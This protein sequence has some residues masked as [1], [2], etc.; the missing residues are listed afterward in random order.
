VF[1]RIR[2]S[3]VPSTTLNGETERKSGWLFKKG[4]KR[5]N[6]KKRFFV[7]T[8]TTLSY[9][10][11]QTQHKLKG[12]LSLIG[13]N[14]AYHRAD[15]TK[16]P[17]S[18]EIPAVVTSGAS[19]KGSAN[20]NRILVCYAETRGD[21]DSWIS[22]VNW[23]NQEVA[24]SLLG[25][26]ALAV[27]EE[28][29]NI[30]VE[31]A[32]YLGEAETTL[33]AFA[34][35]DNK[36]GVIMMRCE[37]QH[38]EDPVEA[39]VFLDQIQ[40]APQLLSFFRCLHSLV[41][42]LP[43]HMMG[44]LDT[45]GLLLQ[46]WRGQTLR[47]IT[48]MVAVAHKAMTTKADLFEPWVSSKRLSTQARSSRIPGIA[49]PS[50]VH[51]GS[52]SSKRTSALIKA[53]SRTSRHANK[54]VSVGAPTDAT[55]GVLYHSVA[56]LLSAILLR[57]P[58]FCDPYGERMWEDEGHPFGQYYFDLLKR[59]ALGSSQSGGTHGTLHTTSRTSLH[60]TSHKHGP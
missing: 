19:R 29:H 27:A 31:F 41:H 16:Y 38:D 23:Q 7:L 9:Y 43:G 34:P 30:R 42:P 47:M 51:G 1:G 46:V 57:K 28:A 2:S 5:H 59:F 53:N 54:R 36:R 15:N 40:S 55:T 52:R 39:P 3:T 44:T 21:M 10:D 4:D 37:N 22:A 6:W 45:H 35:A 13:R 12:H 17:Y 14:P 60:T 18:F 8:D 25:R 48:K 58:G 32:I 49:I 50:S 11:D 56:D 20:D 33:D 24:L 26:R